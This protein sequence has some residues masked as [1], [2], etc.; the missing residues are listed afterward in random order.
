M[1]SAFQTDYLQV[2]KV[3]HFPLH[4]LCKDSFWEKVSF[5]TFH[6]F[7]QRAGN[8]VLKVSALS[9][10]FTNERASAI[11]TGACSIFLVFFAFTLTAPKSQGTR[12]FFFIFLFPLQSVYIYGETTLRGWGAGGRLGR[13]GKGKEQRLNN[14]CAFF[15]LLLMKF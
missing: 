8:L 10:A 3:K 13:I 7:G 12:G 11:H 15:G 5:W 6:D 4:F 9:E 2:F 1:P 14:F